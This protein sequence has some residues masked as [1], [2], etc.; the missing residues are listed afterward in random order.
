MNAWVTDP[1]VL[2]RFVHYAACVL[3]AGTAAFV[4]LAEPLAKSKETD[5]LRRCWRAFIWIGGVMAA[6]SGAAWLAIVAANIVGTSV[7]AAV[8]N[9]GF[10]S[11][12]GGTQ[13]GL[14]TVSRIVLALLLAL[15]V[16]TD[17]ARLLPAF[18]IVVLIAPVGHAGA[19][20]GFWGDVHLAADAAHLVAAAA[21]LGGLPALAILLGLARRDP[22]TF[23]EPAR[24][25]TARFSWLGM[26]AVGTLLAT[27]IVN[28]WFLLSGP[29]DLLTTQYGCVLA[30]KIGLF[31]I[32]IVIAA[33]NRFRLTPRLYTSAALRTL[34]RNSLA[35]VLLG[36]GVLFLVAILGTLEPGSHQHARAAVPDD[37]AF[38][39]IHGD[40]AM[41]DVA[42]EPGRPG[43]IDILIH[44][45]HEDLTDYTARALH[46]ELRPPEAD[47]AAITRDAKPASN[48]VWKVGGIT[49]PRA[50]IWTVVL[51]ITPRDGAIA[52]LDGPIVIAP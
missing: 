12:A 7:V 38:V 46:V 39:H 25:I 50:G 51:T 23:G 21:W 1:L 13:F 14:L 28:S 20:V 11:V 36:A 30:L 16:W 8:L 52:V 42:I 45:A 48:G 31:A 5:R 33:V 34:R 32:M 43:P 40:E 15:P 9:G 47:T 18:G 4:V 24:R 41:A 29:G 44:L 49:L 19:Q 35:E 6:L 22:Q 17:R 3:A 37:A 26:A 2:A 27:G 10:C